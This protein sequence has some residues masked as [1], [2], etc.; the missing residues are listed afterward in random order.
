M[1]NT[2]SLDFMSMKILLAPRV[3]LRMPFHVPPDLDNNISFAKSCRPY[4]SCFEAQIMTNSL[5]LLT[6]T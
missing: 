5:G 6:R 1:F 2:D 3:T 4:K